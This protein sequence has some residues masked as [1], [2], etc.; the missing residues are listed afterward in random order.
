MSRLRGSVYHIAAG[1]HAEGIH[2]LTVLCFFRHLVSGSRKFVGTVFPV[3][4]V[5]YHLLGMLGTDA[6]RKGLGF[7]GHA[8]F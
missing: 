3:L 7:H 2:A 1:T 6:H 8:L 4:A 5:I